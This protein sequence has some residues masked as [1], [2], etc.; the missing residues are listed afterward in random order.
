VIAAARTPMLQT[1]MDVSVVVPMYNEKE[2]LPALA[3][4]LAKLNIL[5]GVRR[6]MEAVLIDDGS[7]DGTFERAHAIAE[8]LPFPVRVIRLNPNEGIGGALRTGFRFAV[9]AAIVTY[10]AD[11]P[12][13]IEDALR[14][15]DLLDA[16][17]DVV[18]ASPYHAAGEVVGVPW[19]RLAIS[20]GASLLWRLR[21]GRGSG[22][23][24]TLSCGFRAYKRGALAQIAHRSNGFLATTEL[25]VRALRA[26]LVVAEAPSVLRVRATGSSK[27]K[28]VRTALAHLRFML[29]QMPARSPTAPTISP[30]P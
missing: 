16:G 7:T 14:L 24:A 2:A 15:L 20:R 11:L 9:G 29:F 28:V 5:L 13:P 10:D 22:S 17:A 12:Y 23:I 26:G 3:A 19:G 27:M 18:T 8:N 4:A 30:Q 6:G 21:L 1:A 25:L